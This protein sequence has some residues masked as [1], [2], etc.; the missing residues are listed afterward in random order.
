MLDVECWGGSEIYVDEGFWRATLT[1]SKI[2]KC[3][4]KKNCLG[5]Y[6]LTNEAPVTCKDGHTGPLCTVCT[7]VKD[8]KYM[9]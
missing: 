1:S 4:V 9:R 3:Q 8:E 5:G 6:N 7:F 2:F